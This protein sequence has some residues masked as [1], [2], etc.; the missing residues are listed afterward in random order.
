[1]QFIKTMSARGVIGIPIELR[2]KYGLMGRT[3]IYFRDVDGILVIEPASAKA[4]GSDQQ[5]SSTLI[6]PAAAPRG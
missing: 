1:M 5:A 6:P 2:R 4:A 3:K